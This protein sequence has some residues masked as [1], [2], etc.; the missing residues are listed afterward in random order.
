MKKDTRW[1]KA[2]LAGLR[3]RW[4]Q[5]NILGRQ[6]QNYR[7]QMNTYG[8]SVLGDKVQTSPRG[9]ALENRVIK[10]MERMEKLTLALYDKLDEANDLQLE[11]I[12]RINELKDGR[13]KDLLNCYYIERMSM[14]EIYQLFGYESEQSVYKLHTRALEYF[15]TMAEERGWK[16]K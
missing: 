2:Y 10:W 12:W 8:G 3:T 14:N 1:S 15:E 9:D 13:C 7:D 16:N 5:I 4:Y 11:A 6:I